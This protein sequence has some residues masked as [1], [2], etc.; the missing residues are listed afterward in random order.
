[1]KVNFSG[2]TTYDNPRNPDVKGVSL[3]RIRQLFPDGVVH[4][5]RVTLAPLSAAVCKLHPTLYTVLNAMP[6]LRT[7]L[8]CWIEKK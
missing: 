2:T 8:L 6:L 4:S 7:N 1:M 5:I 3:T